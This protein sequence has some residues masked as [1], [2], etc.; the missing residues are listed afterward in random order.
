MTEA[1]RQPAGFCV[2][3]GELSQYRYG[4]QNER[5]EWVLE[6]VNCWNKAFQASLRTG[7]N[8]C[9]AHNRKNCPTCEKNFE[10]E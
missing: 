9:I 2:T 5:G 4:R 6:C 3:C 10:D 8:Y 7:R 1:S